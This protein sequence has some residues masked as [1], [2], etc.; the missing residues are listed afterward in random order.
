MIQV[1]KYADLVLLEED[2]TTVEPTSVGDVVVAG[3]RL[4]G[5]VTFRG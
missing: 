2:P 4:A 3:T 1:G 5:K